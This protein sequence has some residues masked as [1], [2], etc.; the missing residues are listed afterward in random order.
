MIH[1]IME[2]SEE[3]LYIIFLD[4]QKVYDALERSRFMDI[5]EGYGVGTR[6]LSLL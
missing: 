4:L 2:L 6:D 1:K 3:S 5:L